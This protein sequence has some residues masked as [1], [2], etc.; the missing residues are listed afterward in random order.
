MSAA[1]GEWKPLSGCRVLLAEDQEDARHLYTLSLTRGG[2][3]VTAVD[4]GCGA[5]E[6]W[7]AARR[8][9]KPFDAAVLDLTMPG[10]RGTE[11]AA[12]LRAGGFSGPVLGLTATASPEEVEYWLAAGC[13]AVLRKGLP[14]RDLV[15]ATVEVCLRRWTS[16]PEP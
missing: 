8:S 6:S 11:A 7:A 3:E 14:W 12:A 5:L 4:D 2:A 15:A 13:D 1:L 10:M 16:V 9:R